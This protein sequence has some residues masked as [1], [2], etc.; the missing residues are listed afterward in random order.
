MFG[1][2][3]PRAIHRADRPTI[4]IRVVPVGRA[5]R[6][7]SSCGRP[8]RPRT[9]G[10]PLPS[11]RHP[12]FTG[13]QALENSTGPVRPIVEHATPQ[14]EQIGRMRWFA[15]AGEARDHGDQCRCCAGTAAGDKHPGR[16]RALGTMAR[17]A[18]RPTVPASTLSGRV[19]K[20]AH[21]ARRSD[22]HRNP[23]WR[24]PC[25]RPAT[26][27]VALITDTAELAPFVY[28]FRKR[29]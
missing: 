11:V 3:G 29:N 24:R 9:G 21:T 19:G 6:T 1:V 13:L 10:R 16:L 14:L 28:R 22:A 27:H 23:P 7:T 26:G 25:T 20:G 4:R 5:A 8:I 18:G 15:P 2:R 12:V 17:L